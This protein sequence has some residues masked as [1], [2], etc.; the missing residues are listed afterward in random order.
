[1]LIILG[2]FQTDDEKIPLG[3]MHCEISAQQRTGPVIM[4]GDLN[5]WNN[6]HIRMAGLHG[7]DFIEKSLDAVFHD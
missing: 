7:A 5:P 3:I 6:D 2:L 1:M 4:W